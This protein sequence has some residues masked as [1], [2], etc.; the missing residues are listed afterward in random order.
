MFGP[1]FYELRSAGVP[2][3]VREYLTLIDGVTRGVAAI[4]TDDFYHLARVSLIK[5]ERFYDRFDTVFARVFRGIL[6][7]S[8]D[9][10]AATTTLPDEWLRALAER[11][12]TPEEMAEV[13]ALGGFDALMRALQDRL[14]T[15]QGRHAGGNRWIG[16]NGTSPFGNGG[17]NPAGVQIGGQS[18]QK[19]A[20][21]VWERRDFRDLDADQTLGTRNFRV[22]LRRLRRFGRIGQP[23][24]FDLSSTIRSSAEAGYLQ[25]RMRP[26][27]RNTV[28][29]ILLLDIGG[30]MDPHIQLC[31]Q[32]FSAA[33]QE[34]KQLDWFYFHNCV[35]DFV[36]KNN[37]RRWDEKLPTE[38]MLRQFGPD[39]VLVFVGDASMSPYEITTPGGAVEYFNAEAGAVWLQRLTTH[40]RRIAWLNPLPPTHWQYTPSIGLVRRLIDDRMYPLTLGGLDA[41][42]A[43]LKK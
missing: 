27:R 33:S 43:A 16:T 20:V 26:E 38:Q 3:S 4:S 25:V 35:Y 31:E 12:F 41:A 18:Q 36:W 17:Y 34:F 37:K 29:V 13:E 42:A 5:D 22:A 39:H 7:A 32:L 6:T 10:G 2:V 30:S 28:R 14:D 15:Q 21:K 11:V 9:G 24:E 40:F 23:T 8:A 19:R 1:L